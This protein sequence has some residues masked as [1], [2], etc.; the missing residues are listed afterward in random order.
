MNTSSTH[1]VPGPIVLFGSGETSPSGRKVFDRLLSKLPPSPR[2]ALLETPA[3]FELNSARVI[4]RVAEFFQQRLQ[5]YHPL[6][7]TVPARQRGTPF[8]P[9]AEAILEPLLQA[10]LIFMG[11]GSPT[12]AVRQLRDS[13][14]W[15]YIIAR[16]CLGATLALASAAAIAI[17]CCA[18]PVYEIFKVGDD[19]HWKEGLNL[20]GLYGLQ[21]VFVPHWNNA[22]G[23]AELDTSRCFMGQARFARL[24]QML[25]A[26][27]TVVGLDE[28]TA[29]LIDPQNGQCHVSGLGGVTLLHTGHNHPGY[30]PNLAGSGLDE[31]AE[32][33]NGHVHYYHNGERFPLSEIGPFRPYHPQANLPSAAWQRALQASQAEA[34]SAPAGPPPQVVALVQERQAARQ[35]KD[36]PASDALRQQIAALGWDVKDTPNG[37][38]ITQHQ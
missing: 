20:F 35:R 4:G 16:H 2:L 6:V 8:S 3:G 19:L 21:L 31:I 7:E 27:L 30:A 25:P 24:M 34:P 9:D 29:L 38:E 5:N 33:R 1:T 15:H 12:Y 13:L 10:D 11:P 17:S 26:E 36:W 22:E 18:L 28:S 37:P 14:A 23:G 32:Q